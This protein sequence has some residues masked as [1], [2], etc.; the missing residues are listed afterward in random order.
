[1]VP[2]QNQVINKISYISYTK[3]YLNDPLIV[4]NTCNNCVSDKQ[5][6]T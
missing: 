3:C 1:M 4:T 5:N 6:K 2:I